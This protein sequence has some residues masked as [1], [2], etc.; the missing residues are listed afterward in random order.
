MKKLVATILIALM[1]M[2]CLL[3]FVGCNDDSDKTP[4]G[5]ITVGAVSKK[6]YVNAQGQARQSRD[7]CKKKSAAW[8]LRQNSLDIPRLPTFLKMR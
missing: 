1:A 4:N 7:F 2:S 5:D 6:T 8:N 3:A